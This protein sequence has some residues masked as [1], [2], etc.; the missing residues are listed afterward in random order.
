MNHS[1][2]EFD[3]IIVGLGC[4]GLATA[5]EL[6][7]NGYKVLGLERFEQS[8]AIG[9]SSVGYG[10]IWRFMHTE[11]RYAQMQEES[12]EIFREIEQKTGQ[13]ILNKCGL[14]YLKKPDTWEFKELAKYGEILTAE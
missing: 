10:R 7:K 2:E 11:P 13:E 6:S 5:Y 3:V 9:T 14:L 12:I 4:V 8:G 1:H